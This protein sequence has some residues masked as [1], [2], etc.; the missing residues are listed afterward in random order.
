VGTNAFKE[1]SVLRRSFWPLLFA[2]LFS[3]LLPF[4]LLTLYSIPYP[5]IRG[6]VPYMGTRPKS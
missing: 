6:R 1:A 3:F 4:S 2:F 5:I